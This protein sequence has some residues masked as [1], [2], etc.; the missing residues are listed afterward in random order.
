MQKEKLIIIGKCATIWMSR[1][2]LRTLNDESKNIYRDAEKTIIKI[3]KKEQDI[4][5]NQVCL[6]LY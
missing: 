5:F 6:N 3:T 2:V 4:K 1:V